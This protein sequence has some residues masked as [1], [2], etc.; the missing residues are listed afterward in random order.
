MRKTG[1]VCCKMKNTYIL[2]VAA[3]SSMQTTTCNI[4]NEIHSAK[5]NIIAFD[6]SRFGIYFKQTDEMQQ[7]TMR[8]NTLNAFTIHT[9]EHYLEIG[10]G[11]SAIC[12]MAYRIQ[13]PTKILKHI[14]IP[15]T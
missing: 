13:T 1:S 4:K 12:H 2:I 11:Q 10:I 8:T 9:F 6:D 5:L 14:H 7:K 3:L 15:N